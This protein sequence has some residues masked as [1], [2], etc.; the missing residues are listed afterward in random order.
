MFTNVVNKL[1]RWVASVCL[2]KAKV[3]V[4]NKLKVMPFKGI[5]KER[6]YE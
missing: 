4:A 1:H 6:S 2:T 3:S 5:G